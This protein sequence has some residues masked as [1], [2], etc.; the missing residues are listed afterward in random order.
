VL[1]IVRD[2][3]PMLWAA[4]SGVRFRRDGVR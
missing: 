3:P 4:I 1:A 2:I